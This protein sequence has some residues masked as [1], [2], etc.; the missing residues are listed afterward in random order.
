M[1]E[2]IGQK[3]LERKLLS[4]KKLTVKFGADPTR[5]DLHLGHAVPLRKMR[6][7]QDL[8]H[9]VVF[10]IGD[11]T[12]K[13]GDPTGKDKTR[14]VMTDAEIKKNAATYI[15]QASKILKTDKKL[16]EIRYNS[17]WF[18]KMKFY[19]FLRLM[20]MTTTA[21]VLERDMFQKRMQDGR[22][23]GLHELV[24]P[25]MQGY[26]SVELKADVVL[27]G[28]DQ[29]FNE[30]FGRHYQ[31]KFG[32]EP[33]AMI[34]TR[35]LVGTDG[36]E[37]MSKSL[38]NYI[39]LTESADQMYGK[40]MSIP[41][42]AMEE[43]FELASSIDKRGAKKIIGEIQSENINPRDAKMLLAFEIA[44]TYHGEKAAQKA[45]E[46][47]VS[48]FQRKKAPEN[49][50]SIKISSA[51]IKLTEFLVKADMATS[52]GDARRK[53]EQGG[54]SINSEKVLDYKTELNKKNDNG[55]II[56]AGKLH[57]AKISF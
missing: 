15:K 12:T 33:Q 44:K 31:E 13:I 45:Q 48:V 22:D 16:L 41:D 8:G 26:D 37:K 29:K 1:E 32:Q 2:V 7:F 52:L 11:A 36:T 47:F 17:E 54:V 35:L 3:E 40:V 6:E 4:G 28:N 25:I 10:L 53:I 51:K 55:K 27:L 57:F 23:V 30:L 34:I 50:K 14:P 19:E 46:N 42:G 18:S 39:G 24:Y 43:Y 21:R 20:T 9:K 49:I 38:D 56:K 5:P